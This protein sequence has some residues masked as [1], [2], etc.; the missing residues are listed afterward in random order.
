V[1]QTLTAPSPPDVGRLGAVQGVGPR[2]H[3]YVTGRRPR[4]DRAPG[5]ERITEPTP[6]HAAARPDRPLHR[7]TR[8]Q[9]CS[10]S[11]VKIVANWGV[12]ALVSENTMSALELAAGLGAGG[13]E[14]DLQWTP[15][16]SRHA[17]A[18]VHHRRMMNCFAPGR[19]TTALLTSAN[20]RDG[21]LRGTSAPSTGGV[22]PTRSEPGEPDI[23][24]RVPCIN[25]PGIRRSAACGVLEFA[26]VGDGP[27][28]ACSLAGVVRGS[29]RRSRL[30]W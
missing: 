18:P 13:I 28:S 22:W 2:S 15:R 14:F 19:P 17:Q 5:G 3:R 24:G 1:A 10:K 27:S 8:A 6:R 26:R 12:L 4:A 30:G 16:S 7:N 9:V 29:Q 11:A 20:H 21:E 25:C 23:A